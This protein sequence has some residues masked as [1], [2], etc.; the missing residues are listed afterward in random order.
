MVLLRLTGELDMATAP[1]VDRAVIVALAGNTK[2]FDL[3]LT[4]V[5]FCDGAGLSALQRLIDAVHS[6]HASFLLAGLHPH[7]HRTLTRLA[8]PPCHLPPATCHR[9]P[10]PTSRL[11]R[12][13]AGRPC[14]Q[15]AGARSELPWGEC[16]PLSLATPATATITEL[17]SPEARSHGLMS[18]SQ[19]APRKTFRS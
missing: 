5:A 12:T 9:H 15:P 1:L 16:V 13:A 11:S 10:S 8:A 3:D 18:P 14:G 19:P 4:G 2:R 6:A 7:V 17:G